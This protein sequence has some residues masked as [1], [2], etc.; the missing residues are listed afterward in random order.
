[1]RSRIRIALKKGRT[2][3]GRYD[4]ARGHPEKPMSWAELGDKFRDC[5]ALV[6][7]DRNAEDVVNLTARVEEMKSLTPLIRAL[8]GGRAKSVK[9]T[10]ITKAGS[11]KW[12]RT[13]RASDVS[14]AS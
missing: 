4:V 3:E 1:V 11:K 9:K 2:I 5:A 8:T 6:L 13:R 7:P 12:S 14:R 10:K